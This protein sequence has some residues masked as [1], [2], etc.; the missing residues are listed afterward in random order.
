M[1]SWFGYSEHFL[2]EMRGL[3][4]SILE[5]ILIS[6]LVLMCLISAADSLTGQDIGSLEQLKM[7]KMQAQQELMASTLNQGR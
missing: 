5:K 3:K 2:T 1:K 7:A 4:L 6:S